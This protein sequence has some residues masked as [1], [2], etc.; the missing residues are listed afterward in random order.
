MKS[1][2]SFLSRHEYIIL[3]GRKHKNTCPSGVRID[4]TDNQSFLL[5]NI[6][7]PPAARYLCA[8]SRAFTS[9]PFGI[10][11]LLIDQ[12]QIREEGD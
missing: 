3:N 4:I 9:S 10:L 1:K 5:I 6:V 12:L 11:P 7:S 2:I 8:L